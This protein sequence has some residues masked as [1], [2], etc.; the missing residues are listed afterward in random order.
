M[1]PV[2]D[3]GVPLAHNY[4]FSSLREHNCARQASRSGA[5]NGDALVVR[6]IAVLKA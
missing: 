3:I 1:K 5:N 4:P 2:A 6:H